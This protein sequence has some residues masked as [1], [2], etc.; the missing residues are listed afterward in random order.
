[1]NTKL[2][3]GALHRHHRQPT[4]NVV[5]K[6]L[7]ALGPRPMSIG[8]VH[9]LRALSSLLMAPV[10]VHRP[11]TILNS[12]LAL[13]SLAVMLGLVAARFSQLVML[14]PL[15]VMLGLSPAGV[16][17][18]QR[19]ILRRHQWDQFLRPALPTITIA[20][21]SLNKSRIFIMMEALL[22]V[23]GSTILL[24]VHVSRLTPQLLLRLCHWFSGEV[25]FTSKMSG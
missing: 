2:I 1:M 25:S 4:A 13:L 14:V 10:R 19:I 5:L 16:L 3:L 9:G 12:P 18:L 20:Q 8:Q 17:H 15:L 21:E 24:I 23:R 22:K 6:S 7:M 11:K